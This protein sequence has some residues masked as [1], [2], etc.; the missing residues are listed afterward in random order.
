MHQ[1][2]VWPGPSA[3]SGDVSDLGTLGQQ[4][5]ARENLM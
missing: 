4:V 2:P 5:L 3:L 1:D